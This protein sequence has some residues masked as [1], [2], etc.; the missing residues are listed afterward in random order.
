MATL[1]PA[2]EAGEL[3]ELVALEPGEAPDWAEAERYIDALM[4]DE[5]EDDLLVLCGVNPEN[6]PRNG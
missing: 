4:I 5:I 6:D 2:E 3:V 1:T